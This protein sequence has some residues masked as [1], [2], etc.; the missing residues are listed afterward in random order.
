MYSAALIL[1]VIN[2]INILIRQGRWRT[3]P[4]LGFYIMSFIC[5]TVKLLYTI[6]WMCVKKTLLM[7]I[8]YTTDYAKL[9][10]G[11]IQAWMIFELGV[12]IRTGFTQQGSVSLASARQL[13]KNLR[14]GQLV[15]VILA[16]GSYSTFL[17]LKIRSGN[18]KIELDADKFF[19]GV[20]WSFLFMFMLLLCANIWLFCQI[21]L[22]N[23]LMGDSL[24]KALKREQRV[25][26]FVL[27]FF[28]LS[29]LARLIDT[30]SWEIIR[31]DSSS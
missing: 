13:N 1:C 26:V 28:E 15:V 10:V 29:Y 19:D 21:R 6:F 12:R 2:I 3:V 8:I 22:K 16:I 4:L 5:I 20:A 31:L 14:V 23:K 30:S 27:V 24:S 9:S 17:A 11:L 18:D 7:A 25:L